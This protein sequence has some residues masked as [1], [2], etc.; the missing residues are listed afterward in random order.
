MTDYVQKKIAP[1]VE[2]LAVPAGRF[3]TNELA[4]HLAVPMEEQMAANYALAI[5]A[6]SRKG[7]AYPDMRALHLQLDKLYGAA[8]SV[9]A[10]KS[11]GC[12]ILKMGITT[13]DDRFALDDEKIAEAGLE[14]LMNLLFNRRLV[15]GCLKYFDH[16]DVS[17]PM[18]LPD[19]QMMTVNMRDMGNKTLS[20]MTAAIVDTERRAR[21]SNMD[22]VMYEVSLDN[23]LQRLKQG[24]VAQTVMRLIG[25][26]TGAHKVTTLHGAEK[27]K[28]YSIP[29]TDRLTKKDIEQG[30]TTISNIGSIY[31]EHKG[32]CALLEIIPPQT[33]A[34]AID[35]I[36]KRPRVITDAQGNDTIAVRQ[37][38]PI[39]IAM[40]HRA[41]DYGDI[42]PFMRKL[43]EIFA[44]AE[45]LKQWK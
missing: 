22:E 14:L 25:S 27:K 30:T 8:I 24:K 28:Y 40:D 38:L 41:L 33:T 31:R 45:V 19:G 20:E 26:K 34:F 17:M 36:Q 13:L 18:L 16:I 32:C 9:T 39:T 23:T 1:G 42:V 5:S 4:I 11:G 10:N 35:S 43:D 2:L 7:K 6:V 12:Q 29:A 44:N 3:K 15:R 37:I 21:N